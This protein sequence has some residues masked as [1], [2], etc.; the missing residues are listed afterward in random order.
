MGADYC[1][2]S[3]GGQILVKRTIL[4]ELLGFIEKLTL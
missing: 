3:C 1:G 2:D 4:L